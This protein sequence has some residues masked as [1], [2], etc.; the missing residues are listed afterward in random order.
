MKLLA[1]VDNLRPPDLCGAPVII[2]TV[3]HGSRG[4]VQFK[5]LPSSATAATAHAILSGHEDCGTLLQ[6]RVKQDQIDDE[7]PAPTVGGPPSSGC[8]INPP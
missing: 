8:Q 5:V 1:R 7:I 4:V 2:A 6:F 3:A